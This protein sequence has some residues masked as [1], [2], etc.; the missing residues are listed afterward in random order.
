[1]YS[2]LGTIAEKFPEYIM[3]YSQQLLTIYLNTLK[4]QVYVPMSGFY[5]ALTN[6]ACSDS[7]I[8]SNI[9]SLSLFS[10]TH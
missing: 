4:P 8:L 6:L 9:A 3:P 10:I 7:S 1:M 2:L 5:H